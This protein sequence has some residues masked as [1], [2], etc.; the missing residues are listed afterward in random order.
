MQVVNRPS[1]NKDE[2]VERLKSLLGTVPDFHT[3]KDV[4]EYCDKPNDGKIV[5][6]WYSI[7]SVELILLQ[8]IY[9]VFAQQ[10]GFSEAFMDVINQYMKNHWLSMIEVVKNRRDKRPKNPV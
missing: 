6:S 3:I 8:C 10:L 9:A 5:F 1:N 2:E 4:I 7:P